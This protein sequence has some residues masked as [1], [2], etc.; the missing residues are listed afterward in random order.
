MSKKVP[1]FLRL[2]NDIFLYF[3]IQVPIF[4]R[5]SSRQ[6]LFC[7]A[8][9][10]LNAHFFFLSSTMHT[11]FKIKSGKVWPK[12]WGFWCQTFPS[13]KRW[14]NGSTFE[15]YKLRTFFLIG[16]QY[17]VNACLHTGATFGRVLSVF[18]NPSQGI[19]CIDL[20]TTFSPVNLLFSLLFNKHSSNELNGRLYQYW[21]QRCSTQ[22][23]KG[24]MLPK[25]RN[26]FLAPLDFCFSLYFF[27]FTVMSMHKKY[28]TTFP[29]I[30]LVWYIL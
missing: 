15:F 6:K 13:I 17:A 24:Q 9:K 27:F 4:C 30:L 2:G 16:P 28:N 11:L 5:L 1:F 21:S 12:N 10:N 26:S 3:I 29:K 8:Q 14:L 25:Y 23:V 18:P 22:V 20:L 7:W 19:Q